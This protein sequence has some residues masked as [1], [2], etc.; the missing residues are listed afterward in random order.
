[1]N[2]TNVV[3]FYLFA[4]R[5]G[6]AL[7]SAVTL[8]LVVALLAAMLLPG[9]LQASEG[10]VLPP[11]QHWSF[12]GMF[13]QF[14]NGALK[15]GAQV[16]VQS[17]MAC[18]SI[19]YIK[20]DQLRQLGLNE[21]EV[22]AL[23]E[24]Q[25]RTKKDA[26]I[27]AM[28]AAAAKESFGVVPPDL[29]LITKARKGYEDYTYG[30]LTGYASEGDLALANRVMADGKVSG[31]E[32]REVASALQ[33]DQRHPDKMAE[34]LKRM[35]AGENFNRYFPG[36]FFAMPQPLADGAVAYADGTENSKVQ[37]ARDVVTFLAWAAE[38]TQME[39]KALG[40][41]V[42][43]FLVILTI[44]LYAVKRRIWARVH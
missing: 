8:F 15:R 12:T 31:E 24:S 11:R 36:H 21:V 28:D 43:L 17:C 18:H 27:S 41:K 13:G 14:D 44:M 32:A 40:I 20:F 22:K 19:K 2:C 39:R 10:Q 42:I 23:A 37:L 3:G 34:V 4:R 30:I 5:V 9:A 7:C 35:M 6:G 26:M 33:L 16:A 25:G 1:M 38:P 29:S